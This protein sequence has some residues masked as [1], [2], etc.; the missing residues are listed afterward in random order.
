MSDQSDYNLS[1]IDETRPSSRNKTSSHK[2]QTI[3][4][5]SEDEDSDLDKINK[6]RNKS[7]KNNNSHTKNIPKPSKSHKSTSNKK[8]RLD[9]S[10]SDLNSSDSEKS[11]DSESIISSRSSLSNSSNSSSSVSVSSK[12]SEIQD[13]LSEH[14]FSS[15]NNSSHCSNKVINDQDILNS[16]ADNNNTHLSTHNNALSRG[17]YNSSL[18]VTGKSDYSQDRVRIAESCFTSGDTIFND[19]ANE[20]LDVADYRFGFTP[21]EAFIIAHKFY[22]ENQGKTFTPHYTE[23]TALQGVLRQIKLGPYY[24]LPMRRRP[25]EPGWFD[26]TG[27]AILAAWI[28]QGTTSRKDAK[29]YFFDELQHLAGKSFKP[30]VSAHKEKRDQEIEE[31]RL[32]EERRRRQEQIEKQEQKKY[33]EKRKLAILAKQ[34]IEQEEREEQ[35]REQQMEDTKKAIMALLNPTTLSQFQSFAQQQHPTDF[36]KQEEVIKRCQEDH[37]EVYIEQLKSQGLDPYSYENLN[38]IKSQLES[39]AT[40]A[41]KNNHDTLNRRPKKTFEPFSN[42]NQVDEPSVYTK[43]NVRAFKYE[44][45]MNDRDCVISIARGET[46]TIKVPVHE[47]GN[48]IFWEFATDTYDIGF[49]IYFKW[50]LDEED[51]FGMNN[52]FGGNDGYSQ[53]SGN[54]LLGGPGGHPDDNFGGSSHSDHHSNSNFGGGGS[55]HRTSRNRPKQEPV[56]EILP[57]F[58]RDSHTEV[59]CGSHPYPGNGVYLLKFDNSFSMWRSKTL[60]YKVYYTR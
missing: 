19:D 16:T 49:G 2:K 53:H 4:S 12:S 32:E 7:D 24:D 30:F 25:P 8:K 11:S 56:T 34:E 37:Y 23:K 1:T 39:N 22:K 14:S 38:D 60:Y 6:L 43:P 10:D 15:K 40:N 54:A 42:T 29:L 55:S 13:N 50:E 17:R 31:R 59:Q 57:I 46:I 47:D 3:I 28:E 9:D 21:N 48:I 20:I 27:K 18:S 35:E 5:D 41:L 51:D 33:E 36:E 26:V 44:I 58:R 45:A 52:G